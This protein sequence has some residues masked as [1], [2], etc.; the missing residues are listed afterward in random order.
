MFCTAKRLIKN[1]D[2]S[3]DDFRSRDYGKLLTDICRNCQFESF[4]SMVSI[5]NCFESLKGIYVIEAGGMYTAIHD[6]M[7][8]IISTAIAPSLTNCLIEFADIKFNANRIQLGSMGSL[9]PT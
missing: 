6:R 2:I 9:Y 4:V 1:N 5:Q 7:F 8:D 3:E